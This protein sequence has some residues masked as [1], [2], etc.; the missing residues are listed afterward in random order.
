MGGGV[1]AVQTYTQPP[2]SLGPIPQLTWT[3]RVPASS[4]CTPLESASVYTGLPKATAVRLF[5][6]LPSFNADTR[7]HR[8]PHPPQAPECHLSALPPPV[9][10]LVLALA[11]QVPNPH[12]AHPLMRGVRRG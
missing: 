12:L 2:E 11:R 6:S 9:L 1:G 4:D 5:L 7:L 10:T 3:A 8:P